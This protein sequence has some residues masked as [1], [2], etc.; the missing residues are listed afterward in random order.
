MPHFGKKSVA[1]LKGVDTKLVNVLNQAIKHFD[2]S[3]IEGVRTLETQKEY[4][5]KGVSK[6]LKS[7]HL[8]GRAVDIAP[9][10]IDYDDTERFVYLG[11]FILGVASQL[12]IKIR[13]GLDWDSDTYTKDTGFRD[14][15]H[16]E[17]R[18]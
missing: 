5:A 12:G 16:F 8:E 9:Y 14:E 15:G 4:V 13:W 1:N 3:V 2:F 6:T 18:G 7:K 17:L 10:P 11:G